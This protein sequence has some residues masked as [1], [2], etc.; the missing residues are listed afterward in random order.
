M[1]RKAGARPA[2]RTARVG[3]RDPQLRVLVPARAEAA[4]GS[5]PG[6][7]IPEDLELLRMASFKLHECAR[8]L[9][10]LAA[11]VRSPAPGRRFASIAEALEQQAIELTNDLWVP[12]GAPS[13]VTMRQRVST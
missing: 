12:K 6:A 13:S 11:A 10:G 1:E 7:L 4:E 9:L 5:V 2:V 8:R 3:S